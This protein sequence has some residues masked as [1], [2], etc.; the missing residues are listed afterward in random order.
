VVPAATMYQT[1]RNKNGVTKT[2]NFPSNPRVEKL[3]EELCFALESPIVL[4]FL[5]A[6]FN[7]KL[8]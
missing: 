4:F 8:S 1:K 2:R 6:I 5:I 3:L 7:L